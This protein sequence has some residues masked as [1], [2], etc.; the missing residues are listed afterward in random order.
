MRVI[1]FISRSRAFKGIKLFGFNEVGLIKN[2]YIS[3]CDLLCAL[4][5]STELLLDVRCVNQA[6]QC[7]QA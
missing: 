4:V 1:L 6:L 5:A 7:H 2:Q 3:K